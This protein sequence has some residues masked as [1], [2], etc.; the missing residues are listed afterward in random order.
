MSNWPSRRYPGFQAVPIWPTLGHVRG[1]FIEYECSV[2]GCTVQEN[3]D[4][5]TR[6]KLRDRIV[7][8]NTNPA[9]RRCAS[10]GHS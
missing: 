8:A 5:G 10:C 1:P 7:E 9:K 4:Y 3:A 6:D 2:C